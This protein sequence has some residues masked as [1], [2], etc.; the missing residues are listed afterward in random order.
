MKTFVINLDKDV[1]RWH[2][3]KTRLTQAGI[4]PIRFSA[5]YG[6]DVGAEHD[7]HINLTLKPVI[8]RSMLGCSLSHILLCKWLGETLSST[9]CV[10][11]CEDDVVPLFRNH[12][13]LQTAIATVSGWDVLLLYYDGFVDEQNDV[14]APFTVSNA[15]YVV[16]KRGAE[17]LGKVKASLVHSDIQRNLIPD[18]VVKRLAVPVFQVDTDLDSNNMIPSNPTSPGDALSVFI[19]PFLHRR[20]WSELLDYK[21]VKLPMSRKEITY[22]TLCNLVVVLLLLWCISW[23]ESRTPS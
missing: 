5:V 23:V 4:S 15:A 20:K 21:A 11:I 2:Q 22:R 17:A 6:K 18:L 3:T 16:T 10:I 7:E 14:A 8:P 1:K 12:S 9:E 19:N 13:E